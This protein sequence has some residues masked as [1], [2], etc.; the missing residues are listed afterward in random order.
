M[1]L[2]EQAVS[3]EKFLVLGHSFAAPT[4]G[5]FSVWFYD[6]GEASS[7]QTYYNYLFLS[8]SVTGDSAWV[9]NMDFDPSCYAAYLDTASGK[10]GPNANCGPFPQTSTTN[11]PRTVGWH[12]FEI[13]VGATVLSIL[14]DGS[15][16]FS[17]PGNYS[18]DGLTLNSQG[19]ES[20]SSTGYFD[21]FSLTPNNTQTPL[22]LSKQAGDQQ[23]GDVQAVMPN[24]L[25][26]KV[27][28]SD[29]SPSPGVPI[30]FAVTGQPLGS[31]GSS[32]SVM[33]ASSASDG[34]ASTQFTAGSVPGQYQVAVSCGDG[35]TCA[36]A[37]VAFAENVVA[38]LTPLTIQ[39]IPSGLQFMVDGGPPQTAPQTV[40]LTAGAHTIGVAATQHAMN[41]ARENFVGWND[42]GAATHT[43]TVPIVG[44]T[45]TATFQQQYLLTNGSSPAG[46]GTIQL[47]PAS[48][49]GYFNSGSSVQVTASAS[50]NYKFSGWSGDLAGS[51]NP[52]TIVMNAPHTVTA[53]FVSTTP[54][55][56]LTITTSILPGGLNSIAY[57]VTPLSAQG[58]ISPY[59]WKISSGTLPPGSMSL[60]TGGVLGG[61]PNTTG[62]FPITVTVQDSSATP[63]TAQAS[64]TLTVTQPATLLTVSPQ[65]LSFA[66]TQGDTN[67][68]VSQNVGIL[69]NPA[70]TSVTVASTTSDG[71]AWL[72]ASYT[73]GKTAPGTVVV[74]VDPAKVGGP[75]TYSGQITI[76]APNATPSTVEVNVTF[77]VSPSQA[78]LLSV[79]AFESFALPQN[80]GSGAGSV[81]VSEAGGG[82]VNYNA[83]AS[84]D[85][86]WLTLTGGGSGTVTPSTQANVAFSIS[87]NIPPGFHQGQITVTGA[88]SPQVANIALLI[89]APQP[90]MQLSEAGLTFFVVAKSSAVTLSQSV[91]VSNLY[92]DALSWA[93]KIQYT[94]ATQGWLTVTPSGTSS[95][96]SPSDAVFSVNPAGLPEG[97]YYATVSFTSGAANSP[98][99]V[100]V[101]LDIVGA[102]ALGSSPQLSSSGMVLVGTAG[103]ATPAAQSITLFSPSATDL[104]YT[105]SDFT[106][107]GGN[108]L[109]TPA[110]GTLGVS[111]TA[112]LSIQA[113]TASLATGV[114]YGTVQI[115]FSDGT[116]QTVQVALVVTGGTALSGA[117]GPLHDAGP[118]CTANALIPAISAPGVPPQ[119]AVA[120]TYTATIFDNCGN[121]ATPSTHTMAYLVFSDGEAQ[122]P[123]TFDPATQIWTASWTPST[124]GNLYVSVTAFST[125]ALG[126]FIGTPTEP[127]PPSSYVTVTV[128]PADADTAPQPSSSG[129]LNGAS[130]DHTKPSIVVPGG[131]VSIFGSGLAFTADVAPAPAGAALPTSLA[132]TQ[133]LLQGQPLPLQ[134]VSPGQ[135]NGLIPQNLALNTP[136]QLTVQ[137]NDGAV[138]VPVTARPLDLQPGLFTT[139]NRGTG[140]GSILIA[141]TSTIAGPAGQGQSPVARGDYIEIFATGLGPV[142]EPGG[143]PPPADG[144]PAPIS[145]SPLF[146]TSA[147]ATVT[148]GGVTVPTVF[149][150]LAPGYVGLYQVNVQVPATAATGSAVLIVLTLTD[151]TGFSAS[152]QAGVTIAVQ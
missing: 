6:L 99:T 1:C 136:V 15:Q 108:W 69:S 146:S 65:Q 29:G 88:G 22:T 36:P 31:T 62:S 44:P 37:T 102:G 58:G 130:F 43:V 151:S 104:N 75:N 48:I 68:P 12:H 85:G 18:F 25:V 123:M 3:G 95:G 109:S 91:T 51:T 106:S 150:G 47:S 60:S 148:I 100:T 10:T 39:T 126:E 45:L 103:S 107:A 54:Q 141:N 133:L 52:Q 53:N 121:L 21:D 20:A 114:N 119:V 125:R 152:S 145:G 90:I 27:S 72:S 59:T 84:S 117:A 5:D 40:S 105:T 23:T 14:I 17:V 55:S 30:T 9:G 101:L 144:Q 64:F 140:Q 143:S 138:S 139:S 34:S 4:Q 92:T 134:Y 127:V 61:T 137:R 26:V 35:Y 66:Y 46:A 135:V 89:S 41:G 83:T 149:S 19:P 74:A 71:G 128:R 129:A 78:P 33:S 73:G 116:I 131:Y 97:Q 86:G 56:S 42:G 98:Q 96:G 122:I 118:A 132:G 77:T 67:R 93:T 7:D 147:K 38:L 50:S 87:T 110:F 11:V 142:Q 94:T 28:N 111:G 120:S 112:A 76:A 81:L 82:S 115:A 63:L 79:T 113:N 2:S 57:P 124:A 13:D 8:N 49:D 32:V 80:G 16:V 70:G 24:P